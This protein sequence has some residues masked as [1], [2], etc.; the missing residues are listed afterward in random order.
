MLANFTSYRGGF[1]FL[2]TYSLFH[3]F[4]ITKVTIHELYMAT[5]T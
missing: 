5:T 3:R 1:V 4:F 2:Y